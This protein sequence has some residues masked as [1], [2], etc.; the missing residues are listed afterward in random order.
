MFLQWI[1]IVRR[2]IPL[3]WWYI[4]HHSP[5][6]SLMPSGQMEYWLVVVEPTH[7]KNMSQNGFIFPNF[8]GE[9]IK[10]IWNQHQESYFTNLDISEITVDFP[11]NKTT[12][13]GALVMSLSFDQNHS[14]VQV[15]SGP[16]RHRNRI[17]LNKKRLL[18]PPPFKNTRVTYGHYIWANYYNS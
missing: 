2:S 11:S 9:N 3:S 7:L 1:R 16:E 13:L 18:N 14:W 15:V 10:H 12:F 8:R 6:K 5:N 17:H 4:I